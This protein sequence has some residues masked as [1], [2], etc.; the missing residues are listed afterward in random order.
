[1][2][3]A[4]DGIVVLDLTQYEAGPSCAQM[5]GWLG[6]EVIKI[7][8]PGGEAGRPAPAQRPDGEPRCFLM[9]N[10]NKKSG[11]P[12]LKNAVSPALPSRKGRKSHLPTRHIA[13]R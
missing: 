5:L 1:M 4:L 13:P 6:A 2:A 7:E 11:P 10:G 8:P 9:L 3:K 12:A